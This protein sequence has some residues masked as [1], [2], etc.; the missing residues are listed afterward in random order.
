MKRLT[1]FL[2]VLAIASLSCGQIVTPIPSPTETA[3]PLSTTTLIPATKSTQSAKETPTASVY[4]VCNTDALNLRAL[5]GEE[6]PKVA[7][8]IES[9]TSVYVYVVDVE[10]VDGGRWSFILVDGVGFWVNA[11]YLC[12]TE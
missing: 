11:K 9:G 4:T 12:M 6:F 10:S 8:P 7:S 3:L 5:P 2:L 1:F